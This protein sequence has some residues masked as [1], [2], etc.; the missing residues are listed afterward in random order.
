[1]I[2]Q[3]GN[4]CLGLQ[5]KKIEIGDSSSDMANKSLIIRY[6]P[7]LYKRLKNSIQTL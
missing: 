4:S 2:A 5:G 6:Q 3:L 1:M 7:D